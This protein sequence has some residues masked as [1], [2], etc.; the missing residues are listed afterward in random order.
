M[1]WISDD[2][3]DKYKNYQK[4]SA[5]K[6]GLTPEEINAIYE[7]QAALARKSLPTRQAY[8]D[9]LNSA[10]GITGQQQA[11]QFNMRGQTPQSGVFADAL[12][13]NLAQQAAIAELSRA[14]LE[15][16]QVG[17]FYKMGYGGALNANMQ[18]AQTQN[19]IMAAQDYA[20]QQNVQ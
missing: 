4:A 16:G 10:A 14:Q 17:D 1:S 15:A 5:A 18:N 19:D 20:H 11:E 3:D 6:A 12:T 2:A 9:A 7:Q 13:R 8:Q